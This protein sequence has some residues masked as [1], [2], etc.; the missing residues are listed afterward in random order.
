[1]RI[2]MPLVEHNGCFPDK[3]A[4]IISFHG[5]SQVSFIVGISFSYRGPYNEHSE[6][7][8][9]NERKDSFCTF[10]F[11]ARNY[12]NHYSNPKQYVP[13]LLLTIG[14]CLILDSE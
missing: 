1:M 6:D 2:F 12:Y 14:P 10:A 8:N 13:N 5:T 11:K 3:L 7:S 9:K 4:P